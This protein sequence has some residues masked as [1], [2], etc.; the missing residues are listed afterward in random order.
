MSINTLEINFV[1]RKTMKNQGISFD[2]KDF[3]AG[4][5]TNEIDSARVQALISSMDLILSTPLRR[6]YRRHLSLLSQGWRLSKVS[7]VDP[8]N[9][10]VDSRLYGRPYSNA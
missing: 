2:Q 10:K 7:E 5:V 4:V 9:N 6:P 1:I 3:A 8:V